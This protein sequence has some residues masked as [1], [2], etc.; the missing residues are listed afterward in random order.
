MVLNCRRFDKVAVHNVASWHTACVMRLLSLARCAWVSVAQAASLARKPLCLVS[1]CASG[2]VSDVIARALAGKLPG[3]LGQPVL[4]DNRPGAGGA[5][6]CS[7][8]GQGQSGWIYPA[9]PHG[10]ALLRWV[11]LCSASRTTWNAIFSADAS[12]P[13]PFCARAPSGIACKKR[14]ATHSIGKGSAQTIK[15][16]LAGHGCDVASGHGVT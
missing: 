14:R 4:M 9:H 3:R 7:R 16:R 12:E 5:N 1:G 11:P 15:R 2:G 8:G 13:R 10:V 6:R